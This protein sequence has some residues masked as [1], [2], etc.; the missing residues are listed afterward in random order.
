MVSGCCRGFDNKTNMMFKSAEKDHMD[1]VA[2]KALRDDTII[3]QP[4]T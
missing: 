4:E 3:R 1:P 2:E